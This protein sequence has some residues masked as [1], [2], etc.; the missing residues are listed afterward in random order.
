MKLNILS[1]AVCIYYFVPF[2]FKSLGYLSFFFLPIDMLGVLYMC[3]FFNIF[4][5]LSLVLGLSFILL[6]V[7]SKNRSS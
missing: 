1:L 7:S 2:L 5:I 4:C 6:R 3:V